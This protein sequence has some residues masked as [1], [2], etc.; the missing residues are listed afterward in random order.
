MDLTK[1]IMACLV[2]FS[3]GSGIVPH[4][5]DEG[6]TINPI[7]PTSRTVTVADGVWTFEGYD[8]QSKIAADDQVSQ[9]DGLIHF[10]GTWTFEK[11]GNPDPENSGPD[12]P[13]PE[14]PVDP[15]QPTKPEQPSKPDQSNPSQPNK[16]DSV[17]AGRRTNLLFSS[18][19]LLVSG[20]CMFGVVG[21]KAYKFN[22]KTDKKGR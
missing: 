6:Q 7:Q 16:G 12:Q 19:L 13:D 17:D 14:Q 11:S 8:A 20:I 18:L 1:K 10:T 21:L 15:D 3:M 5:V 2:A 22:E 9:Q 4:Q